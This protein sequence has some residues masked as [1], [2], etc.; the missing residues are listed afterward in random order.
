M[1]RVATMTLIGTLLGMLP[2]FAET[3]VAAPDQVRLAEQVRH[4]LVMLPYYSVF[5]NLQYEVEETRVTLLGEVSRPT[6]KKD[7]E[8]VVMRLEGVTEV[9][10]QVEVLP[11]SP[12][13]N[14]IRLAVYRAIYGHGSLSRYGLGAVGSIHIIVKN[15][16]VRLRGVVAREADKHIAGIVAN[17]VSGVFSVTN[18]LRVNRS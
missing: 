2:L 7:A 13:D 5:D 12:F 3:V 17:G 10:N 9:I 1:K 8:R 6:L 16:D 11:L 18:E 4:E 15:G 14:R